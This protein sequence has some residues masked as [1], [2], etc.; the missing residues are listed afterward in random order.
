MAAPNLRDVTSIL[1]KTAALSLAD[2][3]ATV[4]L[5]NAAASN[6][7]LKVNSIIVAN[8]DGINAANITLSYNSE[9][10]GGGTAFNL[11][12]TVQ[13]LPDVAIVLIGKDT[14]IYLEEDRSLV[15]TASAGGDLDVVCSYEELDDA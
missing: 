8:D 7:V 13:V 4:L 11:A 5:N 9:D 1:G 15:V 14:P 10:D 6:K 12:F 3:S 2:T